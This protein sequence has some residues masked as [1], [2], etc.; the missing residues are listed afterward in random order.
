M[1]KTRFELDLIAKTKELVALYRRYNPTGTYLNIAFLETDNGKGRLF[2]NNAYND[3]DH[4][5]PINIRQEID[6]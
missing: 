6:I 2:I 1:N 4:S 5:K 3:K